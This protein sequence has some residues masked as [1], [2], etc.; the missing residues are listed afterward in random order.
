MSEYEF[1]VEENK[2]FDAL[3]DALRKFAYT[4]AVY[5]VGLIVM[6]LLGFFAERP[7]TMSISMLVLGP[8]TVVLALMFLKPVDNFKR[9]TTTQ[10]Q[11]ISELL[12][13]LG[14]LNKTFSLLRVGMAV[15]L[16]LMIIAVPI[17]L[18]R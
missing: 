1:T 8:I 10:G 4:F 15:F 16:V 6:G 18:M 2:T 5:A 13:A 7:L 17:L 3:A 11:D 14:H 9:I 12:G